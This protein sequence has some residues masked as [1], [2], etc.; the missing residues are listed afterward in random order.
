[1][2]NA[3]E[4][5]AINAKLVEENKKL[6]EA[7]ATYPQPAA[8]SKAG[9]FAHLDKC[10]ETVKGWPSWKQPAA[11]TGSAD[12]SIKP[13]EAPIHYSSGGASAW[14]NGWLSGY[15]AFRAAKQAQPAGSQLF[16]WLDRVS[17]CG[18]HDVESAAET[19]KDYYQ[20]AEEVQDCNFPLCQSKAEQ[21][22]I[23]AQV[24][25]ELYGKK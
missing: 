1:M 4:L 17:R 22:K 7:L 9:F 25:S 19:L 12:N 18:L 3:A 15:E 8:D 16:A 5:V 6:R 14:S 21:E 23:A 13:P 10:S 11:P 24:H 2:F 20:G